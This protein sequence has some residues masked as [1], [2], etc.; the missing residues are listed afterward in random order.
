MSGDVKVG[1]PDP[2]R[3]YTLMSRLTIIVAAT[4]S[5]GIGQNARLPWRLPKEMAYFAQ[6]TSAAPEGAA[7]ALVMGKNTWES[8]PSKFRPLKKRVNIVI[9]SNRDYQLYA[10]A[11]QMCSLDQMLIH[12]RSLPPGSETPNPPIYLHCD[13]NSALKRASSSSS[14]EPKIHRSFVIGGASLYAE[15]LNLP[16]SSPAFVDRILLTR[17]I[18]P[19]FEDCDVFMPDFSAGEGWAQALHAEL[20]TWV[21]FDVPEG[22][23]E[24]K[25][26]QYEFQM[27]VREL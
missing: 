20:R 10:C 25:G 9:S 6:V 22:I 19:A 1:H 5:N 26:V 3:L 13:L 17:I 24:E 8:I 15:V 18:S 23:Q 16:P 27:W 11:T 12:T 14:G 4:R 7:N 21:G 2:A